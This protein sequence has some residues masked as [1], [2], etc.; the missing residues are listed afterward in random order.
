L[1]LHSK[2]IRQW[3]RN[4]S[5]LL[6]S[7]EA[8]AVLEKGQKYEIGDEDV[9]ESINAFTGKLQSRLSKHKIKEETQEQ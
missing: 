9:V 6:N 3:F 2:Q 1:E 7:A 4:I 8:A 5:A